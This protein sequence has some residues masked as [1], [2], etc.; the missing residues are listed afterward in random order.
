VALAK[1]RSGNAAAGN[2]IRVLSLPVS[3][4]AVI[5]TGDVL[6]VIHIA[7]AAE[8]VGY[9]VSVRLAAKRTGLPLSPLLLPSALSALACAAALFEAHYYPP[10]TGLVAQMGWTR[11]FVA[12]FCLAALFSMSALRGYL[13][14]RLRLG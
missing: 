8:V 4:Y 1:E 2:L 3:W 14:R 12:F 6:T 7:L 5:R 10:Q 11:W 9:L 13:W